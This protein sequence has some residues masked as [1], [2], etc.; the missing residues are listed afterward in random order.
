M[1]HTA[2]PDSLASAAA[3]ACSGLVLAALVP[4]A[5]WLVRRAP[6]WERVSLPAGV[7]L[8][9][10]VLTHAWAVLGDLVGLTPPAGRP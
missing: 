6:L 3:M 4:G 5:L 7:A 1:H 9:L 8:P 10:L 2:H